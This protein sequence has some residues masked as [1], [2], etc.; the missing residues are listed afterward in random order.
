MLA[1]SRALKLPCLDAT[2]LLCQ[3]ADA[4]LPSTT[5]ACHV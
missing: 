3:D 5:C 2:G 4:A 1:L